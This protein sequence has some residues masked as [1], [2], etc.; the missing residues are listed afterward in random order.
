MQ[1]II[2][3]RKKGQRKLRGES[4]GAQAIV[5]NKGRCKDESNIKSTIEEVYDE[6]NIIE[7]IDKELFSEMLD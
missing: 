7:S 6:S 2:R 4:M 1:S 3:Y 5:C